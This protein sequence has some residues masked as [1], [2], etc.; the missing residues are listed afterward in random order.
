M[1]LKM[2]PSWTHDGLRFSCTGCGKCCTGS[3]GY[4]WVTEQEIASMAAFLNLSVQ[5]FGKRYLRL[6]KGRFSLLE[7]SESYS[8][9]FL[10][11]NKCTIYP[12]RPTQCRTY[13]WW[14]QNLTSEEAWHK[15][16]ALCEGIGKGEVV[17]Y[18]T[19]E[20]SVRQEWKDN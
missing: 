16:A 8:C 12:V 18:D 15:A 17:P 11:D 13:P 14:L 9:V 4:T 2:L 5:D 19:I 7:E 10:K 1:S 6:V 3:P 20:D